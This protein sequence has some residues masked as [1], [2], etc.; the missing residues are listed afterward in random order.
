DAYTSLPKIEGRYE[1]SEIIQLD[2][3]YKKDD[4]YRNAKLFFTDAFKNAKEVLQYDDRQ[5]GKVI[6]KGNLQNNAYQVVF[7]AVY[8]E[9]RTTNFTLEIFCKDGKYRYRIYGIDSDFATTVSGGNTP[10]RITTGSVDLDEAYNETV[11]GS[12]K[13]L[14]RKLFFDTVIGLNDMRELLKHYMGQKQAKDNDF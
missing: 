14:N 4:L 1:F 5:E 9:K 12:L 10:D 11:K 7:L 6:G 3:T 8:S 2:S 13:K